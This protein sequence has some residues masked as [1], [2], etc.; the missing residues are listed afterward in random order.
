[1]GWMEG[2]MH[3]ENRVFICDVMCDVCVGIKCDVIDV[4]DVTVMTFVHAA[5]RCCAYA[6]LKWLYL[7]RFLKWGCVI[8][9][10]GEA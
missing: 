3:Y 8:V 1:M 2:W 9:G 4:I 6:M 7:K 5:P 10:Q